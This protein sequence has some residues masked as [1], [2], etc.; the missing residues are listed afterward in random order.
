MGVRNLPIILPSCLGLVTLL[1]KIET[2]MILGHGH[3]IYY[4]RSGLGRGKRWRV[5]RDPGAKNLALQD[6]TL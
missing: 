3:K 6:S 2:G 4:F 1:K 5:L